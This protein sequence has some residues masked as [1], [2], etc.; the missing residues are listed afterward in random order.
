MVRAAV[1]AV[2]LCCAAA[3]A[4]PP[5]PAEM[6]RGP[7]DRSRV[8]ELVEA[9]ALPRSALEQAQKEEEDAAD[10]R[11][12][13]RILYG[14][15]S[16]EELTEQQAEEMVA[17]A[18]RRHERRQ[19]RLERAEKLVEAGAL[20]RNGLTPLLEEFDSSRKTLGLAASRARLL[21]ELAAMA[22]AEQAWMARLEETPAAADFPGLVERYDGLAV[23]QFAQ[24]RGISEAFAKRFSKPLPVSARGD[25]AVHRALGFDHRGRIDVAVDPDQAEGIWLR[26]QLRALG[27]PFIALRSFLS[28]RSTGPHIHIGPP[29]S[30]LRS[31]GG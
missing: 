25:T 4:Q 8:P 13:E 31:G 3:Q 24:L 9:G 6:L 17:A 18:T 2:V 14:N 23:F 10:A 16:V 21:R 5:T 7:Q 29:S 15:V 30:P 19:T 1:V 20:P 27:I 28:G 11:I 12:L 26:S 22:R